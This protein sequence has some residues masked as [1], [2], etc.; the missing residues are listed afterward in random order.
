MAKLTCNLLSGRLL[1]IS[2]KKLE[3]VFTILALMV[4]LRAKKGRKPIRKK[5]IE[6]LDVGVEGH[7]R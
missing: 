2:S 6:S 4:S 7:W 5:L 1:H 3:Q